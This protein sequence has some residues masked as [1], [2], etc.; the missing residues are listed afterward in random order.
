MAIEDRLERIRRLTDKIRNYNRLVLEDS[1]EPATIEDL[2]GNVEDL[3]GEIKVEADQ[4]KAETGQW[5]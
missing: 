4:I 2:K 3:C 1:L 5:S